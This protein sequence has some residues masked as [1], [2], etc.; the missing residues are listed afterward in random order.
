MASDN[1]DNFLNVDMQCSYL[2]CM[3]TSYADDSPRPG[4]VESIFSVLHSPVIC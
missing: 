4:S 2:S 1:S 3:H